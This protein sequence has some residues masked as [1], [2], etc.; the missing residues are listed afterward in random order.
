MI[1]ILTGFVLMVPKRTMISASGQRPTR[2]KL[3]QIV[4]FLVA[5][6]MTLSLVMLVVTV[7]QAA[8][9]LTLLMVVPMA[10]QTNM[11]MS[12][13]MRLFTRVSPLVM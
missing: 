7:S 12:V 1:A 3:Q 13:K 9:A 4:I 11:A 2:S 5:A 6:V 10:L 8:L